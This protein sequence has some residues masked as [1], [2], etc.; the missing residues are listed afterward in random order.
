MES[1]CVGGG[2][3]VPKGRAKEY[4]VYPGP[5]AMARGGVGDETGHLLEGEV[6]ETEEVKWFPR[7][8][9]RGGEFFF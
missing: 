5:L 2:N 6:L 9:I 1:V 8:A 4:V 3:P 7:A